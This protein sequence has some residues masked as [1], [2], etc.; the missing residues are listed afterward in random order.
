MSSKKDRFHK[1]HTNRPHYSKI[2][3][4]KTVISW[5]TF[6]FSIE[7]IKEAVLNCGGEKATGPDEFTF[8]F[9]KHYWDTIDNIIITLVKEFETFGFIPWG[10]N[11][12]FVAL[13][14][15][16]SDPLFIQDFRPISLIDV[17]TRL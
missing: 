6:N 3:L 13:I 10:Y 1:S 2:S 12:S 9:I 11:S 15:K 4:L 7:E 17:N 8:K 5:A 14:P 16:V